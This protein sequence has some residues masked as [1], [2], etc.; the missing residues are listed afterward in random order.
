M[1]MN[2]N[3][4]QQSDEQS[5]AESARRSDVMDLLAMI[6]LSVYVLLMCGVCV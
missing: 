2:S 6:L 1:I 5:K 3:V 4:L